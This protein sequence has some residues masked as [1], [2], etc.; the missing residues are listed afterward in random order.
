MKKE[1]AVITIVSLLGLLFMYA[2]VVKAMDYGLFLA[3][4]SKSPLLVKYDK[5]LLGPG[6][7][8]IEF[9]IVALL[10]FAATRKSGLFLS[11]FTMLLFTL[12]LS[13]LYFFYTNIPCSCGG[14]LGKMSYPAHIAFNAGFT[15]LA[16]TGVLLYKTNNAK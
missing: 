15:L 6:V 3:D 5:Q 13:T 10:S 4:M 12:Y 11:F 16:A 1:Y 2:A 14:I 7:L 9:L 8:G